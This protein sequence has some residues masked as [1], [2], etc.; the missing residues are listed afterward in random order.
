MNERLIFKGKN[1]SICFYECSLSAGTSA[2]PEV[3]PEKLIVYLFGSS[4]AYIVTDDTVYNIIE[5]SV[6]MPDFERT[7]FS[8]HAVEN[9]KFLKCVFVMNEWDKKF[10]IGWNLT[11]PFFSKYRD[12]V[13]FR[14]RERSSELSS[15]SLIQPFQIGH[16]SLNFVTGLEGTDK[17]SGNTLQNKWIYP[18]DGSALKVF[19]DGVECDKELAFIPVNS[20]YEISANG[21]GKLSYFNIEYFEAEDI[22]KNYLA[23]IYN[24]RMT[25][26]I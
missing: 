21:T 5:P 11:M 4:E 13:R 9:I 15:W 6:F 10:Y 3:D 7:S 24:G 25:E 19:A 23:Q 18:V 8:I 16:L 20:P 12:A 22:Q 2:K 1:D 17:S 26:V 14:C